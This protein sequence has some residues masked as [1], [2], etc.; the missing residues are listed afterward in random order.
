M[1]IK[2]GIFSEQ[3]LSV[4]CALRSVDHGQIFPKE[5]SHELESTSP[6][7][8]PSTC[9]FPNNCK[10]EQYWQYECEQFKTKDKEKLESRTCRI[11][12]KRTCEF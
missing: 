6:P 10:G 8:L 11:H 12:L 2:T 5:W 4:N 1:Q 9:Y 3:I 7:M